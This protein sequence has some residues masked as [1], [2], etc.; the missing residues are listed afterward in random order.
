MSGSTDDS[1]M[2]RLDC[3]ISGN[4]RSFEREALRE[5][6]YVRAPLEGLV[7]NACHEVSSRS[8][9]PRPLIKYSSHLGMVINKMVSGGRAGVMS[10]Q[11]R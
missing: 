3:T 1:E 8:P 2:K 6:G 10:G 7:W 9:F 11:E 4:T 5:S